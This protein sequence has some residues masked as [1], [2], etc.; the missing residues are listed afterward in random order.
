MYDEKRYLTTFVSHQ[1]DYVLQIECYQCQDNEIP[2]TIK[3]FKPVKKSM[4]RHC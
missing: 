4:K 1:I 2:V 3:E